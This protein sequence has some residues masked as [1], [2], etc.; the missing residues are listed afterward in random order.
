MANVLLQQV[1]RNAN[2]KIPQILPFFCH[3]GTLFATP[4]GYVFA[5]ADE[6]KNTTLLQR[7]QLHLTWIYINSPCKQNKVFK[8]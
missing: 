1:F 5:P 8:E 7:I 3:L 4:V 2:E 6:K